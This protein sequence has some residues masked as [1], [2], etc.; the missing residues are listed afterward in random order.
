VIE[1]VDVSNNFW[2][3]YLLN[4]DG[5]TISESTASGNYYGIFL[6]QANG[7]TLGGNMV[8]GNVRNGIYLDLSGSSILR[9]NVMLDHL[10]NFGVFGKILPDFNQDIDTSNTV[11]GKPI[12]YW[13]N[14]YHETV[15]LD[16]GYVGIV[17]S[18]HI[19][20]QD[21]TL[22]HNSQCVLFAYTSDSTIQNVDISESVRGIWLHYSD[23]NTISENTITSSYYGIDLYSSSENIISGNTFFSNS[24]GIYLKYYSNSNTISGNTVT[25]NTDG[26]R[27]SISSNSNTISGNTVSGNQYGIL[28]SGSDSNIISGNTVSGNFRDIHLTSSNSNTIS[29]NT[30]TGGFWGI[31]LDRSNSDNTIS[32]NTIY[33]NYYGILLESSSI[34]N[35]INE[36]TIT[37]NGRG[38]FLISYSSGNTVFHN[39]IIDNIIQSADSDPASN[40]WHHPTLLEGNYWSDYTG[41]D[42]GSGIDKHAIAGDGIGDTLIAHPTTEYDFYPFTEMDGWLNQPPVANAGGP[43]EDFEGTVITFDAAL[44]SDPDEDPLEYRWDFDNNGIWDTVWSNSPTAPNTW[45]DDYSGTAAV[46]VSD[47]ILSVTATTTVTVLNA[48]PIISSMT[49]PLDPTQ[50]STMI[51]ISASFTDPGILDTHTA[52]INWGD[53]TSSPGTVTEGDGSGT[54]TGSHTYTTPG[55]YLVKLIVIDDDGGFD[56][57]TSEYVVIYDPT[58]AFVTGG[59]MIDSP[60]GAFPGDPTLTGKAGFGFVSK[61]QKGHTIPDGNTQFRFHA[62]DLSFQSTSYDWMVVAGPKV[63]FKGSGEI[64]GEGDYQFLLSAIDGDQPGGGGVDRFRIKIWDKVTEEIIYDNGFGDAED[65]DPRTELTHGSIKIHKA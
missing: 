21:L 41:V 30:V 37:G 38:I 43:Y 11:D 25:D 63:I 50:V 40:N 17:D 29:E 54:A 20:V 10:W 56:S 9:N 22:S 35:T 32:G 15:P 60:P 42:D 19:T 52:S 3:I 27:L 5:N 7:N 62:A 44:S 61:Y 24:Y 55:V 18:D 65:A 8:S 64:N 53:Q 1:N 14:R 12:Y 2:G 48:N 58:G 26:I 49:T 23:K 31:N 39:N 46:E 4:S 28:L 33:S 13:V 45:D 51:E 34:S 47:G 16:A 36:N 57:I 6:T 59:G